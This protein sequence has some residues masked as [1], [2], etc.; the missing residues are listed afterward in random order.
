MTTGFL[1]R[2]A[3]ISLISRKALRL[4]GAA[5]VKHPN[6]H[7]ITLVSSDASFLDWSAFLLHVV[8]VSDLS[9]Q[10]SFRHRS[11]ASC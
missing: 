2:T 3:C 7:L 8:W 5:R 1:M 9:T 10:V 6:G 11:R 4:S